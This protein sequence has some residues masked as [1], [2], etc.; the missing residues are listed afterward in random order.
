MYANNRSNG[1]MFAAH[2]RQETLLNV[3]GNVCLIY[4]SHDYNIGPRGADKPPPPPPA[5]SLVTAH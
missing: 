2:L 4:S 1:Q 5:S 3:F